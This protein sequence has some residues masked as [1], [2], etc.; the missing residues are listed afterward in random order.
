[1]VWFVIACLSYAKYASDGIIS[2]AIWP[3]WVVCLFVERIALSL[4]KPR[5]NREPP[6]ERWS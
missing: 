1:M 4:N 3:V 2:A 5:R 6:I